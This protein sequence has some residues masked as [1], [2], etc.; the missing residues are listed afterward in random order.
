MDSYPYAGDTFYWIILCGA[1]N[2]TVS[3]IYNNNIDTKIN[4]CDNV[5]ISCY[6]VNKQYEF[7]SGDYVMY[8]NIYWV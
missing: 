8:L 3:K 2:K 4:K 5:L 7:P 6:F 1:C